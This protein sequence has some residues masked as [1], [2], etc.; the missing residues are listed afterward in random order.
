[1]ETKKCKD[2]NKELPLDKFHYSNKPQGILKSYCSDCSYQRVK[3]HIDEDPVAHRA[4]MERYMRENPEKYPGNYITKS[5]PKVAGVYII[6]CSLTDDSYVGCSSNLRNR[7]YKHKRNNGRAV[8]KD[9]SKLIKEYGW[10]VF[11]FDVLETCDREMIFERESFWI[12]ELQ[13][14]LNRNKK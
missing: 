4:Y 11:T 10:E 1:M 8:Q 2:C 14:N 13:P 5:R 12:K 7:Y 9:L 6:S 3:T